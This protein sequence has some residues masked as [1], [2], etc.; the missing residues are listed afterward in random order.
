MVV[1]EVQQSDP[2]NDEIKVVFQAEPDAT[3]SYEVTSCLAY[4][5]LQMVKSVL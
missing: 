5:C 4:G 2:D 3:Y 1:G